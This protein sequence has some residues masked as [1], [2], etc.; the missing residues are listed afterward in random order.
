MQFNGNYENSRPLKAHYP[1][2]K[3]PKQLIYNYIIIRAWK[4]K[5][6]INKMSCQK[7]KELYYSLNVV[8]HV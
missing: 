6:L 2:T 4:Y 1:V 5:Q 7:I 3:G 8:N